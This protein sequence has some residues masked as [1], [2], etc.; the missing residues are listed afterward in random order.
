MIDVI[1]GGELFQQLTSGPGH[2]DRLSGVLLGRLGVVFFG[3][4]HGDID[5]DLGE[6]SWF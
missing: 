4:F 2:T 3:R 6:V 1:G 5:I